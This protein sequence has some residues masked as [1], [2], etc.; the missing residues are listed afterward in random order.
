MLAYS[1]ISHAGYMLLAILAMSPV[2]GGSIIY[3]AT[4]YSIGSIASFSVLM[5]V[6]KAK[7]SEGFDSF[8]GLAKQNPI[9]AFVMTIAMLSLAGIPPAAGFF[10]KYYI[11]TSA[12]T[13][14]FTSLVCIAVLGSLI[15]VYYYLRVVIAMYFRTSDDEKAIRVTGMQQLL[16][17]LVTALILALGIFPDLLLSALN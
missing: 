10:A 7:G 16:M 2:S 8:N 5:I 15:S 17:V 9:L 6:A 1:S 13:A 11:F 4:S 14:G 12:M 3:Y